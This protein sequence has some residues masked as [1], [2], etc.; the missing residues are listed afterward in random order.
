ME[1][2]YACFI[3]Q[4]TGKAY[5]LEGGNAIGLEKELPQESSEPV[6]VPQKGYRQT[7]EAEI[8][9]AGE[10]AATR[11]KIDT[12]RYSGSGQAWV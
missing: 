7:F 12:S 10:V 8:I 1:E 5:A 6:D 9:G 11:G 2:R 3:R 4:H